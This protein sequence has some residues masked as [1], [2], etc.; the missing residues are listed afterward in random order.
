[1]VKKRVKRAENAVFGKTDQ[2]TNLASCQRFQFF[3]FVVKKI[4]FESITLKLNA[5]V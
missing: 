5:G 3:I 1:M 2:P 4:N